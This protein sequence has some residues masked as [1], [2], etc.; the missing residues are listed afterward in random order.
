MTDSP[1]DAGPAHV[2]PAAQVQAPTSAKSI[3]SLILGI[4]SLPMCFCYGI[5]S[6]LLGIAAIVLGI[7]AKKDVT[8]GRVGGPSGGMALAGLICGI[9]GVCLGLIFIILLI[10]GI[11]ASE[12]QNAGVYSP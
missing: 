6:I 3:V 9:V 2:H 12:T 4:L 8:A 5:F 11:V 1:N 7:L 10:I